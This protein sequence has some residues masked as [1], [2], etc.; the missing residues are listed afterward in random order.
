M[1]DAVGK[2]RTV[3]IGVFGHRIPLVINDILACLPGCKFQPMGHGEP[4]AI[5][6]VAVT[7]DTIKIVKGRNV[8]QLLLAESQSIAPAKA[9]DGRHPVMSGLAGHNDIQDKFFTEYRFKIKSS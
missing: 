8:V 1:V 5:G 3:K 2:G 9:V 4:L 6:V 7:V